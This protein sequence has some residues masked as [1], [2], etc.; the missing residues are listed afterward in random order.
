MSQL[1]EVQAPRRPGSPRRSPIDPEALLDLTLR[2][3]PH[4]NAGVPCT[5]SLLGGQADS[6]CSPLLM[7]SSLPMVSLTHFC[8]TQAG[9]NN[10]IT[11]GGDIVVNKI[12]I[13]VCTQRALRPHG[14]QQTRPP[15]PSPAPGVY[16]NS[17]PSSRR[18]HPTIASSVS[19][20]SCLQS[21][22]ASGSFPMSW[23]FTS[24]GQ[25]IG[26]SASASVLL[27]NIQD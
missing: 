1:A 8:T 19:P 13:N 24:S 25:S 12:D 21:F 5:E 10:K 17:C 23:L 26:V 11:F 22:P 9:R 20:F 16:P 18:C 27:M 2:R 4:M 3:G 15:C 14:L 6:A 7:G